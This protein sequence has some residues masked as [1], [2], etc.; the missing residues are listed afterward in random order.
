M[1]EI[2]KEILKVTSSYSKGKNMVVNTDSQF[3]P[4]FN[5]KR[6]GFENLSNKKIK[7]TI[8]LLD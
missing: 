6:N 8:E 1:V 7:I 4:Q 5:I 2:L 3:V